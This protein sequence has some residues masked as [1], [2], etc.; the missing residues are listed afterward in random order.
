MVNAKYII[1]CLEC[2]TTTLRNEKRVGIQCKYCHSN[3]VK[4]YPSAMYV[5][6]FC[7][8]VHKKGH[9]CGSRLRNCPRCDKGKL[10]HYLTYVH[11]ETKHGLECDNVECFYNSESSIRARH[12]VIHLSENNKKYSSLKEYMD[13][14]KRLK[15]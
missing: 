3:R 9:V 7:G 2:S 10:H 8:R 12:P 14:I 6:C 4:V 15:N 13:D 11:R 1:R 5:Y